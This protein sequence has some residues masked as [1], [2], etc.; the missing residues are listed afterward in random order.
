MH[1]VVGDGHCD[2]LLLKDINNSS[3][4]QDPMLNLGSKFQEMLNV[5]QALPMATP[6]RVSF[7]NMDLHQSQST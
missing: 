3:F 4:F 1:M 5:Q 7:L 6:K 2:P